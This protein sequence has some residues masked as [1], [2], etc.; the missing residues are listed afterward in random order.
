MYSIRTFYFGFHIFRHKNRHVDEVIMG[1]PGE[2][3]EDLLHTMNISVVV[4]GT[5]F[6]FF[7]DDVN[8]M[9]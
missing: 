8:F 5:I 6:L 3:T 4:H 7:Y 1:A 2:V 9:F